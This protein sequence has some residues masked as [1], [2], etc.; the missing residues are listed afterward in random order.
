MI[1]KNQKIQVNNFSCS[2]KCICP[3]PFSK[4]HRSFVPNADCEWRSVLRL[5]PKRWF[6]DELV[7]SVPALKRAPVDC[8]TF[9][10]PTVTY[11]DLK[12]GNFELADSHVKKVPRDRTRWVLPINKGNFHWMTTAIDWEEYFIGLYDPSG[13]ANPNPVYYTSLLEVIFP[14]QYHNSP[15]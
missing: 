9:V 2:I 8:R 14:A 3:N 12:V 5:L 1:E 13:E 7:N 11:D 6:N 15:C 4:P 10:L